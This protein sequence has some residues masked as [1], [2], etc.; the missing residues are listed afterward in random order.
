MLCEYITLHYI[1]VQYI[2]YSCSFEEIASII[3]SGTATNK[4][5]HNKYSVQSKALQCM[6]NRR[7]SGLVGKLHIC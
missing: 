5:A 1:T 3:P 4:S 7:P 6:Y 2:C